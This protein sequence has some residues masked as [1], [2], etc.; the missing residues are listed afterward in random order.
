MGS[1]GA[2]VNISNGDY[3]FVSGGQIYN[4][5]GFDDSSNIKYLVQSSGSI[6]FTDYSHIANKIYAIFKL[7][8]I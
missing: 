6:K 8:E 7:K 5:I 3:R 1:R 2:F 4:T